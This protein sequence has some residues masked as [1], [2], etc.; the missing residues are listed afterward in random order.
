MDIVEPVP[1]PCVPRDHKGVLAL[2]EGSVKMAAQYLWALSEKYQ[3]EVPAVVPYDDNDIG[4]CVQWG[5]E[6]ISYIFT[7]ED[8]VI[9]EVDKVGDINQYIFPKECENLEHFIFV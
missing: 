5:S 8:N 7:E 1:L 2:P 6:I 9:I 4:A 3:Q